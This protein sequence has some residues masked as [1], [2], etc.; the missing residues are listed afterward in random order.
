[1]KLGKGFPRNY[2]IDKW[3]HVF[4]ILQKN[5]TGEER[6]ALILQYHIRLLLHFRSKQTLNFPY[7][8]HKSLTKMSC[9]VRRNENNP[10]SSLHHVGLI[11]ILLCYEL[12]KQKDSWLAFLKRNR[13]GLQDGFS[14]EEDSPPQN[15]SNDR[16]FDEDNIP[17]RQLF[18]R[19]TPAKGVLQPELVKTSQAGLIG[20]TN[21]EQGKTELVQENI[22]DNRDMVKNAT[23]KKVNIAIETS[24]DIADDFIVKNRNIPVSNE[25]TFGIKKR[26]RTDQ[27]TSSTNKV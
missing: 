14:F 16:P 4:L 9:Q 10:L 17:L 6:Y 20:D 25:V 22:Q 23:E 5:V 24:N 21:Q 11:K 27:V 12:E 8:L 13:I 15:N 19:F 2:L 26:Q 1:M 3:Q 7:F 18:Q